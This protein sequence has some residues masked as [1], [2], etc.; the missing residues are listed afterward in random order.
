M[1]VRRRLRKLGCELLVLG[2]VLLLPAVG[3]AQGDRK[4]FAGEVDRPGYFLVVGNEE[5]RAG[6]L[7]E[8]W[9]E[10][11]FER[12]EQK[13]SLQFGEP[14]VY[15]R[16]FCHMTLRSRAPEALVIPPFT[17]FEV[18]GESG[19]RYDLRHS[20][21]EAITCPPFTWASNCDEYG[22]GCTF[23]SVPSGLSG[24]RVWAPHGRRVREELK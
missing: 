1:R 20:L 18:A 24:F 22:Q 21:V 12:D 11:R 19:G 17:A 6:M 5:I 7:L 23:H 2:A 16:N 9:K 10:I 8:S 13:V 14:W 15:G 4:R 3:F